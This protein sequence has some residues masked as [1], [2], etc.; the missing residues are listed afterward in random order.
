[1]DIIIDDDDDF[2]EA[3][4]IILQDNDWS[5]SDKDEIPQYAPAPLPQC[6]N[7]WGRGSAFGK[8]APIIDRQRV[9]C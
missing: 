3:V 7:I 2:A 9:Y 8:K 6:T 4:R 5:S 1:M